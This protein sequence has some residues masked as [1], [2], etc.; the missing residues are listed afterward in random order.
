MIM[1]CHNVDVPK[2]KSYWDICWEN[3]FQHCNEGEAELD[4]MVELEQLA[5]RWAKKRVLR[6]RAFSHHLAR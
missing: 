4:A 1:D 3:F 6:L 2:D 5:A